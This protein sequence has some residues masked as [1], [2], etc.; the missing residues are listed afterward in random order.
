M[1]IT[2]GDGKVGQ[3]AKSQATTIN[4]NYIFRLIITGAILWMAIGLIVGLYIQNQT[5]I[6]SLL[7]VAGAA[8]IYF[9]MRY[10]EKYLDK[11]F[12]ED[13]KERLKW[14]RGGQA[15]A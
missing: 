15:E 4:R 6:S 8:A 9:A 3:F 11:R 5:L 10:A 1:V 12:D 7:L 2:Y 14:L 13:S